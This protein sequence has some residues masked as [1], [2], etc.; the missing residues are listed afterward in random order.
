MACDSASAA[1]TDMSEEARNT[2]AIYQ[3]VTDDENV[4]LD[5][6]VAVVRHIQVQKSKSKIILLK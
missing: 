6:V 3:G 4:D 2:L 1:L 5:L